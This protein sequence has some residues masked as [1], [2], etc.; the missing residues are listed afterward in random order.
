VSPSIAQVQTGPTRARALRYLRI[1]RR[2][3]VH[4]GYWKADLVALPARYSERWEGRFERRVEAVLRPGM[5]ILDVGSGRRPAI[6][7]ADRPAG[8]RYVGL[9]L[10]AAELAAAPAGSYDETQTTDA[11]ILVPAFEGRFDLVVSFQVLEHVRSLDAALMN[12][13]SYL[14]PGGHFIG[15]FSGTFSL[16]GLA[17]QAVPDRLA[18]W[19]VERLTGRSPDGVFPAHYNHCW[20]RQIRRI[21]R[22]WSGAVIEPLYLGAGYFRF[23]PPLQRLYLAY[24]NW[25]MRRESRDLATH[26]FVDATR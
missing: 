21:L 20:D 13:Y 24:E 7:P 17:N 23:M 15:Q 16:F 14:V 9:D 12:F 22:P 26:Y 4:W 5:A 10:S 8:C 1:W 2:D 6:K 11:T 25:L 18:V 3:P 19:L